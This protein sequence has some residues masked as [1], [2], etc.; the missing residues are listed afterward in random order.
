MNSKPWGSLKMFVIGL[1][2]IAILMI[3]SPGI[4]YTT[5]NDCHQAHEQ[6]GHGADGTDGKDGVD[7]RDGVAGKDGR[8]GIDG[9]D[10]R[11]GVD[12][13]DGIVPTTWITETR[14]NFLTVN[15]WYRAA[16]EA[17]AATAAMQVHLPQDRASR[18]TFGMSHLN[19]TTGVGVGYAY[20]LDNDRNTALTVAVGV[21]GD[22]TAI[23]GSF[24]F[25]FGSDRRME[26][27]AIVIAP[28]VVEPEI[29][30]TQEYL[31]MFE[32]TQDDRYDALYARM[33]AYEVQTQ[34][35][36]ADARNARKEAQRLAQIAKQAEDEKRRQLIKD[37]KQ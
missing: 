2:V 14:D 8:D 17:A 34:K 18:L 4:G 37:L 24:G 3:L 15:K 32:Q 23:K 5:E 35:A 28:V 11:D 22:E 29:D 27:P 7:G 21:A 12:G 1:I 6:C 16:R 19:N 13:K 10:G 30:H 25:E 33:E 9:A 20:K 26:I 31:S 36:V